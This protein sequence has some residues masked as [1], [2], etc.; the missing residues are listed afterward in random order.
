MFTSINYIKLSDKCSA[1]T[2]FI[3]PSQINDLPDFM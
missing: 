2:T 3:I 1:C